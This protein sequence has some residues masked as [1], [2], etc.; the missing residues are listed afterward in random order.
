MSDVK[1]I[2][3]LQIYY[4]FFQFYKDATRMIVIVVFL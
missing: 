1:K 4:R 3:H 2:G